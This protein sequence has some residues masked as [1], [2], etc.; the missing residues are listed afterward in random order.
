MRPHYYLLVALLGAGPALAQDLWPEEEIDSRV[1]RAYFDAGFGW[2]VPQTDKH[3]KNQDGDGGG[4]LGFGYRPFQTFAFGAE[5]TGF[6]QRIDTPA[7]VQAPVGFTIDSR[8]RLSSSGVA[9]G[10]RLII[11]FDRFEPYFGLGAGWYRS[12]LTVRATAFDIRETVA[13]ETDS[14]WG[15]HASLG[16]DYW[17]RPKT[18]LGAELRYTRLDARFDTLLPGTTEHVG[19]SFLMFRF[20]QAF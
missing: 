10:F 3:L 19:G 14:R 15:G 12:K 11:P 5:F 2:F 16:F 17:I 20:R 7:G 6:S 13:E 4:A 8:S 1:G 9:F 18:A